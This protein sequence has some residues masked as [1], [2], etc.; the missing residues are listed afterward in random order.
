MEPQK[1]EEKKKKKKRDSR[2]V[3]YFANSMSKQSDCALW[4]LWNGHAVVARARQGMA[5]ANDEFH[6]SFAL[7]VECRETDFMCVAFHYCLSKAKR[8][9]KRR[10]SVRSGIRPRR[11]HK[12]DKKRRKRG[13]E[14]RAMAMAMAC[15]IMPHSW[16]FVVCANKS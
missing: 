15:L 14:G 1:E 11:A 2:Y 12:N 10:P 13:K 7:F 16:F 4:S 5:C 9:F 8:L 3:G 6:S